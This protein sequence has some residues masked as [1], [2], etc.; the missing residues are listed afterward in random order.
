MERR[1]FEN[2]RSA[3]GVE[4]QREGENTAIVQ[5]EML[6]AHLTILGSNLLITG[7]LKKDITLLC[8]HRCVTLHKCTYVKLDLISYWV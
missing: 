1:T 8:L 6:S 4:L 7:L 2:N 3:S 5:A